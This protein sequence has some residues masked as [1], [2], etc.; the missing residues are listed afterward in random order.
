[1]GYE[2]VGQQQYADRIDP[3]N[4]VNCQPSGCITLALMSS[5]LPER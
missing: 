5:H 2:G 4:Q 1:M 3:R